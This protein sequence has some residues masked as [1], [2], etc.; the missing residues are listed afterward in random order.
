MKIRYYLKKRGKLPT[1]PLFVALY[2]GDQTELIFT[3][4]R[5][6][7]KEWNPREMQPRDQTSD[8]FARIEKVKSLVQK[9]MKLLEAQDLPATPYTIKTEYIKAQ[10]QKS[11]VQ[12]KTDKKEKLGTITMYSLA[13]AYKENLPDKFQPSTRKTLKVSIDQFMQYLDKSGQ[14]GLSKKDF[15]EETV[16]SYCKYLLHKRLLSDSTHNKRT[17]HLKW[18]LKSIGINHTIAPR[19]VRRKAVLFLDAQELRALELVDVTAHKDKD[20]HEY[21]Q[22]AKDM[23]LLG[24][25]TALRISDLKRLNPANTSGKEITLVLQ[26][27]N[28]VYRMPIKLET[29][30][31]LD[32]YEGHAP[33][34]SEQ[35]VNRS[36]KD[37]CE[38]AKIDRPMEVETTK[39]G[40]RT[41]ATLPKYSLI[42]SHISGKTFIS[43]SKDRYQIDLPDVAAL[44]GKDLK[45]L[46]TH[47]FNPNVE[48]AIEKMLNADKAPMKIAK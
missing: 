36:I 39:G 44:T 18:F 48:R 2:D 40:K 20:R 7:A 28:K 32:K 25:Y 13:K 1:H 37:I 43:N 33:R 10:Q 5:I 19:K 3:G 17:K 12:K 30:A 29:Q 4:E 9:T 34:I 15:T 8:L 31:I 24:C 14:R 6:S 35:E 46:L 21:M 27:N 47:Y 45:T 16:D 41:Y 38:L 22:R 42:T 11:E 23:F 26:K